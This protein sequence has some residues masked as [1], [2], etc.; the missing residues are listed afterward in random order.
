MQKPNI[1]SI[2]ND[3]R[4]LG[5]SKALVVFLKLLICS[6]FIL[7]NFVL[8]DDSLKTHGFISQG[9]IYTSDNKFQGNSDSGSFKLTEVGLNLSKRFTP[10]LRLSSQVISRVANMEDDGDLNLDY[11]FLDYK[12]PIT[13]F[14]QVGVR[15][16]RV[17]NVIGFY[18]ET[19]DVAFTRP[20]IFV[21]QSIYFNS[22]RDLQLS[23][24]GI[25][26]YTDW[27]TNSGTTL[28]EFGHGHARINPETEESLVGTTVGKFDDEDVNQARLTY[29]LN[30]GSMR[31]AYSFVDANFKYLLSPSVN[32]F[33]DIKLA[34]LSA[35]YA[36][37]KTVFTAE[38][39]KL[40]V[41][42][43]SPFS[44]PIKRPFLSWYI[45]AQHHYDPSW[46]FYTRYEQFYL[47]SNDK[48]GNTFNQS[49]GLPSHLVYS[50]SFMLG[51]KC[52]INQSWMLMM[53]VQSN[54][55][56]AGLELKLNSNPF[57]TK[58]R[59][60]MLSLMLSYRF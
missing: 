46:T 52:H 47:D 17:K 56:S 54:N 3:K 44:A 27:R 1:A 37:E 12:A 34:L 59:W 41:L 58:Q 50:K 16:G 57:A 51:A 35:E 8:A 38:Y 43:D 6:S 33:T 49:T 11:I 26:G 13:E 32:T 21:P 55:G 14:N 15:A 48:D 28:F 7:H 25:I 20:S 53:E 39:M 2:L 60:Q 4:K 5:G 45:Q 24:D 36:V 10:R 40:D 19:R 31:F 42:Y 22:F 29:S 30:D 9:F 23:S 18:N